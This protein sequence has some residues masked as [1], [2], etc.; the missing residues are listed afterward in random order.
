MQNTVLSTRRAKVAALAVAATFTLSACGGGGDS[1]APSPPPP[2]PPPETLF[3]PANAWTGAVPA[4]AQTVTPDE[5]RRRQ[6]AGEL[7]LVTSATQDAQRSAHSAHVAAERAFLESQPDLSDA[8]KALLAQAAAATD[9]EADAFATLPGGRQVALNSLGTAIENAAADHRRARDP[10]LALAAYELSYT[11]LSD[12]LKAQLPAPATLAGATLAQIRQ[13]SQQME[14]A[15]ATQTDIDNTRLDPSAPPAPAETQGSL[16]RALDFNPGNGVDNNGPCTPSGYARRYHFPLRNF[17]SPVKDQGERGLCWAFAAIAAVESRD[18]VQLGTTPDLSEQFLANRVKLLWEPNNFLDGGSAAF[19]LNTAEDRF[20]RLPVETTWTYNPAVGR[21]DNAFDSGVVGTPASYSGACK[22]ENYNGTCSETAHQSEGVCTSVQVGTF[23]SFVIQSFPDAGLRGSRVLPVW[24][25]GQS[26]NVGIFRAHLAAGRSLI[27]VFPIYE[28]F[29][30]VPTVGPTRGI[31]SSYLRQMRDKKGK[32][33]DGSSGDHLA[34]IVG[35]V[36]NEQLSLPGGPP[37]TVGGG[38]YFILRNSWGCTVGDAGYYYVPA[39]YVRDNFY[40]LDVLDMLPNRSARWAADQ[41]A[42][43]GTAGLSVN[44]RDNAAVGLRVRGDL[45]GDIVVNHPVANYARMTVTS[46]RDGLLYDGQWLVNAPVGGSL[47]ANSLPVNFQ[48]EGPRQVTLVAHYG[49]QT[50]TTTKTVTALN[51][52]PVI[53]FEPG[54]K[55]QQNENAVVNALVTDLNEAD[56]TAMCTAMTWQVA[57]PDTIVSGSGCSRVIRF[58]AAGIRQVSVGTRDTEGLTASATG[59]FEVLPPPVNPYPRIGS[60]GV[61]SRDA[62]LIENQPFGCI[63]HTVANNA[64]IDLRQLGCKTNILGPDLSRY[65]GQL[66]VENPAGEA[67]SYDWTYTD[68]YPN[69]TATPRSGTARTTTPNVEVNRFLYVGLDG[70]PAFAFRCTID[71]R[72]NA[73][74]ASRSKTLRVWSGQCINVEVGPR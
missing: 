37:S 16:R 47:F 30:A 52:T 64:V 69:G 1:A 4:G 34:Q 15:L 33:V 17:V 46:D 57:A 56:P 49:S 70:A 45:A 38:G 60:F 68:Y 44:L 53:T 5:F 48:T 63:S 39:D 74:E 8:V 55:P 54:D 25:S 73:P 43:G 26:W 29:S 11:L 41:V 40:S 59:S 71:V 3:V 62:L 28:G 6:M 23:C 72:V 27:G 42:P 2:T 20:Q 35:F 24:A 7:V 10:A 14:A 61:L 66:V 36:S 65:F 22:L 31:V 19:A 9:L 50:V 12:A 67:L 13:A 51:S 58:G 32:L 21:P 18:Q